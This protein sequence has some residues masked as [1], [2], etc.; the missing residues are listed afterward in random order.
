MGSWCSLVNTSAC[1]AEDRR[2]KSGRARHI[3]YRHSKGGVFLIFILI[4]A[5]ITD[6]LKWKVA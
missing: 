4:F 5:K 6:R 1:H 3:E 2:F